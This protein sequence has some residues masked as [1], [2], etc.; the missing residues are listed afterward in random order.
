M[1][2]QSISD[3]ITADVDRLL[4]L[5]FSLLLYVAEGGATARVDGLLF[6]PVYATFNP[7]GGTLVYP[8]KINTH[9][10]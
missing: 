8:A 3:I 7:P 9:K 10:S 5:P 4:T 1:D 2:G 6:G